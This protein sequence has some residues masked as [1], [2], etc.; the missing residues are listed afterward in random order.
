[1]PA[2][3]RHKRSWA[4]YFYSQF[5]LFCVVI[6]ALMVLQLV[7][8]YW[9]PRY[10]GWF[11]GASLLLALALIALALREARQAA[12][13]QEHICRRLQNAAAGHIYQ[14]LGNTRNKGEVGQVAWALNDLLDVIETYFKEASACFGHA[15]EG[16][17]SRQA[18][19]VGLPGDFSQSL[20]KI[21]DAMGVMSRVQ[22][23]TS[24][25]R[26]TAGLHRL[27]ARHL[28]QDLQVTERDLG[29]IDRLMAEVHGLA[30]HSAASA[31]DAQSRVRQVADA[32]RQIQ[33]HMAQMRQAAEQLDRHRQH[34]VDALAMIREITDQTNLLAL[35]ASIEAARAGEHG[36]GFSVV[37]NEVRALSERTQATASGIAEHLAAFEA[38]MQELGLRQQQT[39]Q[40][41]RQA[42]LAI[43]HVEEVVITTNTAAGQTRGL[44]EQA[45]W[46]GLQSLLKVEQL[47]LKQ[48]G[49]RLL[50]DGEDMAARERMAA[51]QQQGRFG[52][53]LEQHPDPGLAAC[54]QALDQAFAEALALRARGA[55]DAQLLAQVERAEHSSAAWMTEL[56]RL[57]LPAPG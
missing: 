37:A 19:T 23:L 41:A 25:N 53:W 33:Q 56:S 45:R 34:I 3:P 36:R 12:L 13:T 15:A 10:F 28:L 39:D 29:D 5:T 4:P 54:R 26:L 40:Q 46:L 42:D 9:L 31:G 22:A 21:N 35:N 30:E 32:S 57:R 52:Q 14:R 18:M 6:L 16:D 2:K 7:L 43:R 11:L 24:E 49:Y 27:N 51:L 44:V 48:T 38:S 8:Q 17:F 50:E 55:D 1:M 20:N 47:V